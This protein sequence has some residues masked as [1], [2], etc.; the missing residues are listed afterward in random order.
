MSKLTEARERVGGL[1][2]PS[3][4]PSASISTSAFDCQTGSKLAEIPG[5]VCH[6]CYARKGMYRM[7]NV[8]K[9]LE[10]RMD[11]L[12]NNPNWVDDMVTSINNADFFRWHDSGDLQ[13]IL[14]LEMIAEVARRMPETRFWLPTKEHGYVKRW[15]ALGNTVPSNLIIR[16]SAAMIDGKAPVSAEHASVVIKDREALA[17]ENACPAYTQEGRCLDCRACWNKDIKTIAYPKH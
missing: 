12:H 13:S 15:K 11:A 17:T 10:R 5:S 8:K 14:H 1:S 9:A 2:K 3:K 16:V 6:G 7:P 4:M